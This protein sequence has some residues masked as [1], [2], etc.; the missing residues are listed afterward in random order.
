[1]ERGGTQSAQFVVSILL[2]RLL[3]PEDFGLIAL[4]LIFITLASVFVQ[5][6]FNTAL[7]QKKTADE[8]DFS[9]VFYASLL[10]AGLLYAILFVAAPWLAAYFEQPKLALL[11]RVLGCLLFTGSLNSIQEAYV[12]RQMAFKKLF[13]R[14]IGAVIPSGIVGVGL[15]YLGFGIW[16]LVWQQLTASILV[17]LI[18]WLTVRWRPKLI[19]SVER[20]A[21]LLSF[22]WKLLV[23]TLL[24][25]GYI[26]LRS[27]VI[28]K[29]FT[30]AT[31]GYYSRG[32]QFPHLLIANINSSIQS[33]MLPTFS[34]SQDDRGHLK[35][36]MRR[37]IVTSSFIIFPMMAG[38]AAVATPLVRVLL[39][40]KWMPCVPFL[41]IYCFIYA[42]WP[43]HTSNL[44]A[45]NAMGRSDIFLKLEIIKK[46]LG[47]IVLIATIYL[48]KSAIGIALGGVFTTFT[49]IFLNTYPNKKLLGYGYFEQLKDIAPSFLLAVSMGTLTLGLGFLNI[50]IYLLLLLQVLFGA[51]IYLTLAKLLCLECL[52]YLLK[53]LKARVVP[54]DT[55]AD[56]LNNEFI[57]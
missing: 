9:S 57:N 36:M 42:F 29:M 45:I 22:G 39:G 48:F 18:M 21:G 37:T 25:T 38:L 26:N 6:G 47:V 15:A 35:K 51:A 24:D 33:V 23:S 44:S 10:L 34:A 19:F 40:E 54:K 4:V 41:Q 1:M 31:L 2:A 55:V 12:I 50:N 8:V 5:S 53:V 46:S 28:G 52:D 17:C 56:N 7:I 3:P 43:I 49:G 27:L 20:L 30:P 14:S 11:L 32:T 16:A 13:Y